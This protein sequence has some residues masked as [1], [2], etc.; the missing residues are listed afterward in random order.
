MQRYELVAGA[1]AK[2]WEVGREGGTVT[3][4]F[5][6]IGAAGQAQVKTFDDVAA[7]E[8]HRAKLVAEKTKKG[9][10][11]ITSM[12]L[13]PARAAAPAQAAATAHTVAQARAAAQAQPAARPR[14]CAGTGG[15]GTGGDE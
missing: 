2:F 10:L 1:S 9:Y 14:P 6:R 8:A 4:R 13:A 11:P 7:A 5:G 15:G 3:V 12:M